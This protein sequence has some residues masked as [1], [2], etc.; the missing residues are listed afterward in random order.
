MGC[1]MW[2]HLR[3]EKNGRHWGSLIGYT[4]HKLTKH[5]QRTMPKGYSWQDY[6][7]GRLHIDHIIPISAFNFT[8][9]EH[10]DFRRC[11]ALGNL[12]LL[13]AKENMIKHN[14]L[15]KPFQLALELI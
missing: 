13:P 9:S 1:L 5:L 12:R 15:D 10:P 6:L 2:Q 4:I 11:W 3:D 14:K 7:R 8:K